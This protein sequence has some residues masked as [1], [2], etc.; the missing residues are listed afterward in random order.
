MKKNIFSNNYDNS[1][2]NLT[3]CAL[4]R[5]NVNEIRKHWYLCLRYV[6]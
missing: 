2:N 4:P 3:N 5:G 1:N 6:Y